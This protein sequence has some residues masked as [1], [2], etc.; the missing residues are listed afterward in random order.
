MCQ[1]CWWIDSHPLTKTHVWNVQQVPQCI[2]PSVLYPPRQGP[3]LQIPALIKAPLRQPPL[4]CAWCRESVA[5]LDFLYDSHYALNLLSLK[6]FSVELVLCPYHCAAYAVWFPASPADTRWLS[7]L[8]SEWQQTQP[9]ASSASF[10][11][12]S[13]DSC[14]RLH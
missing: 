5:F 13:A 14:C 1:S 4:C 2:F 10:S 9:V 3:S 7:A 8:C 6:S 12:P 11:P